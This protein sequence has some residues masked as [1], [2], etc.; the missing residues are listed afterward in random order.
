[1]FEKWF[2]TG[3][4][5]A[6]ADNAPARIEYLVNNHGIGEFLAIDQY[7]NKFPIV[8]F[9]G[10]W[11]DI[12]KYGNAPPLSQLYLFQTTGFRTTKQQSLYV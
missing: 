1:M 2:E 10:V 3:N 11:R 7:G 9:G 5:P 4:I 6:I 12:S 8:I